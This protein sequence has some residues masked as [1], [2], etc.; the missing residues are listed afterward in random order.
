MPESTFSA[1]ILGIPHIPTVVE[2]NVRSGPGTN[3]ALLFKSPLEV[4]TTVHAVA[5]DTDLKSKDGKVYTWFQLVFPDGQ[6]G[7]VRDDLIDVVGDGR[8]FGYGQVAARTL[9]FSLTRTEPTAVPEAPPITEPEITTPPPSTEPK[10]TTPPVADTAAPTGPATAIGRAKTGVNVRPGP[11]TSYNPPVTR[12]SFG[13]R[14]KILDVKP[15]ESG[16]RLNWVQLDLN[17]VVGWVRE[18]FLRF[19]GDFENTGAG[20]PDRYPSP[21]PDSWWVRDFNVDPVNP[22]LGFEHWG[23][24]F[25]AKEGTPIYAGPQGGTAVRTMRCTR[26]TPNAPSTLMQGLGLGDAR[27]LNDPAWGFGYGN[28]VIVRYDHDKLPASTQTDLSTKGLAG[29]HLFALYGH[30]LDYSVSDG[31]AVSAGQRIAA[32]GNTG[33][34]EAAHLH[35]ELRASTNPNADWSMLRPNLM[36]PILLFRR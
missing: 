27:V 20:H 21:I 23:W 28:F 7:W 34:S 31:Q 29:A 15:D 11:G 10:V 19:E 13:Q 8:A 16:T 9:A 35:L 26:C 4:Q 12:L 5:V 2:I 3:H 24:D 33:N 32:C 1:V 36:D 25:G 17:G 30:L 22:A 6:I 14:G 18:D